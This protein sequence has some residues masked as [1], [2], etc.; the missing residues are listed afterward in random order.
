VP[1]S[2]TPCAA[3]VDLEFAIRVDALITERLEQVPN[4]AS[5]LE[6][7]GVDGV[8][9]AESNQDPFFPS[10]LAAE[11]THHVVVGTSIAV[12]LARSPMVLAYETAALQRLAPGRV[13]IGLGS[14]IEAHV[15]RRFGMPWSNPVERMREYV[16]AVRTIWRSWT[17]GTRLSFRGDYY[18]LTFMPEFAVPEIAQPSAV[19][20][21]LGGVGRQMTEAAGEVADGFIGHPLSTPQYLRSVSLPAL[22]RGL[23]RRKEVARRFT[24]SAQV[25]V[26]TGTDKE[27]ARAI[28]A[29]RVQL[30]IWASTPAYT[31]IL[32]LHGIGDI[33]TESQ[34]LVARRRWH[35][36]SRVIS[37]D[38]VNLF[39]VVAS[40]DQLPAKLAQRFG[41]LVHR[42]SFALAPSAWRR[43]DQWA[44]VLSAVQ[45]IDELRDR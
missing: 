14:Q 32:S 36:I 31:P 7:L 34:R 33:H 12:A 25:L 1:S 18:S 30:A 38:I 3:A 9:A 42:L 16:E 43:P 19:P 20:L 8:W 26:A 15:N 29:C 23:A 5:R 2:I 24:V 39:V 44:S 45:Q 17:T 6:G 28:E 22:E 41:S 21:L 10:L 40:P 13:M 35:E 37:D 4:A 27:I 11:H